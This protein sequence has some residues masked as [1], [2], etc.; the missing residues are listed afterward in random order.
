MYTFL[1][2]RIY[3]KLDRLYL[4]VGVSE[5]LEPALGLVEYFRDE[6]HV[7][8]VGDIRSNSNTS[9]FDLIIRLVFGSCVLHDGYVHG[10][11]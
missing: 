10:C 6:D 5:K 9:Q 11:D 7:G 3:I 1:C 8:L 4:V 2:S